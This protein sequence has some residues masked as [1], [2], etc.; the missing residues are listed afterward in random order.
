MDLDRPTTPNFAVTQVGVS[1]ANFGDKRYVA[2]AGAA[3][4]M[5][6][7]AVC[8]GRKFPARGFFP[9]RQRAAAG[10]GGPAGAGALH[11]APSIPPGVDSSALHGRGPSAVDQLG[12]RVSK[13]AGRPLRSRPGEAAGN[14]PADRRRRAG[15]SSDGPRPRRRSAADYGVAR[16]RGL[17]SRHPSP[18]A[19]GAPGTG[20]SALA[21][22]GHRPRR[23]GA[24]RPP[25]GCASPAGNRQ[26]S[27]ATPPGSSSSAP[28][29]G[30]CSSNGGR[31][32]AVQQGR[33]PRPKA[34]D[35][36]MKLGVKPSGPGRSKFLAPLGTRSAGRHAGFGHLGAHYRGERLPRQARG[37][38]DARLAS[39]SS[40]RRPRK[41]VSP[42]PCR[43]PMARPAPA[44]S[45]GGAAA[46]REI[47]DRAAPFPWRAQEDLM[48]ANRTQHCP[49]WSVIAAATA[50][51]SPAEKK[52]RPVTDTP[53]GT[54]DH[55][56]RWAPSTTRVRRD[57]RHGEKPWARAG[58]VVGRLPPSHRQGQ[59]QGSSPTP[60]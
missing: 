25:N 58:E 19:A 22:R 1:T 26:K 47:R 44:P 3:A 46:W 30:E 56:E 55:D 27:S 11:G 41:T 43:Q 39:R 57:G 4:R 60:T 48:K 14:G 50:C 45:F 52:R 8:S 21:F 6:E 40:I 18:P 28:H 13:T 36:A 59:D 37:L 35:L 23:P 38:R 16:S 2:L 7:R 32:P 51:S 54:H 24:S 29:G 12:R 9:L 5:V 15:A 34:P 10:R 20:A 42:H 49:P 17:R 31:R 53:A 33:L